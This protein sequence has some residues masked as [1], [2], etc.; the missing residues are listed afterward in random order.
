M[1]RLKADLDRTGFP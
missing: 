1:F